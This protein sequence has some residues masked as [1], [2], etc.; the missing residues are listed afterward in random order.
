MAG[1]IG[2]L[3]SLNRN[4]FQIK[5]EKHLDDRSKGRGYLSSGVSVEIHEKIK[6]SSSRVNLNNP[7]SSASYSGYLSGLT[8]SKRARFATSVDDTSKTTVEIKR[9]DESRDE[10]EKQILE[11]FGNSEEVQQAKTEQLVKESIPFQKSSNASKVIAEYLK[12][13][14]F[15]S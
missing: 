5:L 4:A 7:E 6:E 1:A 13:F 2:V 15:V 14:E 10:L 8:Y 9:A 12:Q 3:T 11:R